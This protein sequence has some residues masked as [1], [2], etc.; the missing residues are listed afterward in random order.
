LE[1]S[2]KTPFMCG[3]DLTCRV[4]EAARDIFD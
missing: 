2:S 1:K 4:L 3:T